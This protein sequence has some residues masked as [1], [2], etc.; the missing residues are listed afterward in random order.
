MR[1]HARPQSLAEVAESSTTASEFGYNLADFLH[2]FAARPSAEML[3]ERP[4]QLRDV[5]S[6]GEVCDAYLAATAATLAPRIGAPRPAWTEEPDR[7]LELVPKKAEYSWQDFASDFVPNINTRFCLIVPNS[8]F[9]IGDVAQR[10]H[11]S[12]S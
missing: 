11:W 4:R 6:T 10:Q 1:A 7:Y 3:H 12:P 9:I 2:E 5:F 8:M